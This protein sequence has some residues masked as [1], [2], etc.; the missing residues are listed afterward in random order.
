MLFFRKNSASGFGTGN[1]KAIT[2]VLGK[3]MTIVGDVTF[4]GMVRLEG[5]I[6][7]NVRG[8]YLVLAGTGKVTGNIEAQTFV[9]Q[10]MWR[11]G[12]G[13][14]ASYEKRRTLSVMLKPSTFCRKWRGLEWGSQGQGAGTA[15][16]GKPS[17]GVHAPEAGIA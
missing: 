6:E 2:S 4:K 5:S 9:C 12:P 7:G 13:Q 8:E 17:V 10:V 15:Y 11:W 16:S 1:G 14:A 3:E